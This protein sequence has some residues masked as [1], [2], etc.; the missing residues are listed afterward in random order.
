MRVSVRQ[1]ITSLVLTRKSQVDWFKV[2]LLREIKT[3][4]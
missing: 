2:P 3:R 4:S 1:V